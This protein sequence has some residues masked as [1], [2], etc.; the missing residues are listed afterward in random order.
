ME[1]EEVYYKSG[2]FSNTLVEASGR[3]ITA[4]QEQLYLR[5]RC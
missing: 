5:L 4:K 2:Y 1:A 3:W